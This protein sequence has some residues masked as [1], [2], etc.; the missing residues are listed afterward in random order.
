MTLLPRWTGLA[1]RR[2]PCATLRAYRRPPGAGLGTVEL[3]IALHYVF[4]TPRTAWCGTWATRAIRTRSSPAGASAWHP[5]PAGRPGRLSQ[6]R[7]KPLR[8]LRRRPFQ[9]LDQRRPG[10]GLAAAPARGRSQGRRGDRRRRHDRRHGLRG[11]QPC[12]RSGR[13]PAGHPQRQ[14]HVHLPN[15]GALSNYLAR[16]LS[17]QAL[18]LHARGQQEGAEHMPAVWELAAAPRST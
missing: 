4:N 6:A 7:R 10:H 2:T 13:R 14:R 15:V 8:H 11:P 5:A 12:R 1:R 9:H 3:T 17:G 18:L 16:M